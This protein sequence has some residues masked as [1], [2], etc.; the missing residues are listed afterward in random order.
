MGPCVGLRMA[1]KFGVLRILPLTARFLMT[2]VV[3]MISIFPAIA[4][5]LAASMARKNAASTREQG[6][7]AY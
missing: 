1:A 5:F 7:N 3:I 6:G 4:I 2:A